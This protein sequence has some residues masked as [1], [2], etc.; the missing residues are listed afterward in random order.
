MDAALADEFIQIAHRIVWATVATVGPDHRP[1]SRVL[2]PM[3]E[4][5]DGALV[6]WVATA[7]TPLKTRHLQ[8]SPYASV[9]YWDASHDTVTA[10]CRAE[11]ILGDEERSRLWRRFEE[12]PDPVGYDPSIIPAWTGPTADAFAGL[13]LTPWRVRVLTGAMLAAGEPA[14]SW[15]TDA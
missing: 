6:G 3:W 15:R 4:W 11:W 13:R 14:R 7:P 8:H 10:D 5:D 1:R 2:H 9:T 12:A